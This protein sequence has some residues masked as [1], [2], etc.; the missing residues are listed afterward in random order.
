MFDAKSILE[1]LVKGAGPA[2]AQPSGGGLGGLGDILGQLAGGGKGG[3]AG[4]GLGG[5]GDILGQLAGAGGGAAGRAPT[6]QAAPSQGGGLGGL[7]DILGQLAGAGGHGQAAPS[8]APSSHAAPAQGG[9]GLADILGQLQKQLGGA[10]GGSPGAGGLGGLG[11]VLGQVFGQARDGVKEGAGKLN[12]AT[13]AGD[14]LGRLSRELSGKSPDEILARLKEVVGNNQLGAG[15]ALGGLGAVVLGTK[16][17]RS[18]AGSA[19][20]L[21]ALALIGGL[22]Y[23]AY[24]NYQTGRPAMGGAPGGMASLQPAPAG[25]GFEPDAVTNDTAILYIRAMIGAAAADGRIDAAE[26]GKILGGLKQAGLGAEAEEFLANELNNPATASDLAAAVASPEQ[27]V[28]VY[29]AARIAIDVDDRSEAQFLAD[30]AA[31]LGIDRNL[32]AHIEEQARAAG[33][34]A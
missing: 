30:L 4:G 10:P 7:G 13:G 23:K 16:A 18:L 33:S 15:A 6:P 1:A 20:K 5:L 19:I 34:A 32:M 22:A 29:T 3:P 12:E 14:V 2:Q 8:T 24:Q 21:G 27:A 28:Q 25:S 17:G 9:G 11:D 26:Q 31:S